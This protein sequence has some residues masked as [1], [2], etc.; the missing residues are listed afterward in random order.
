MQTDT[1]F[2]SRATKAQRKRAVY[3]ATFDKE[4]TMRPIYS[5]PLTIHVRARNEREAADYV[6]SLLDFFLR[7]A[8]DA[9]SF[10]G[11]WEVHENTGDIVR[12]PE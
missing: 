5:V 9:E 6:N 11:T 10:T 3:R 12:V 8:R 1:Y 4:T 7:A 2:K